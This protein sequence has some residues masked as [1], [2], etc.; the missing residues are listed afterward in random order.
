MK[1]EIER[2]DQTGEKLL[3]PTSFVE[4]CFQDLG[5]IGAKMAL[6]M[7]EDH[8]AYKTA[9]VQWWGPEQSEWDNVI[10]LRRLFESEKLDSYYG[11][12]FDQ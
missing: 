6:E 9:Q 5:A 4:G 8:I 11:D 10:E 3:D 2:V 12:F 7:M 1:S